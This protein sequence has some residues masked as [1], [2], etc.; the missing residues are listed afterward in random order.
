MALEILRCLRES[1]QI[2]ELFWAWAEFGVAEESAPDFALQSGE[3]LQVIGKDACGGRFCV[4]SRDHSEYL[5][6]ADS[7]GRAGTIAPSLVQGI[8]IMI[9][10]PYWRDCLK[11]SCGGD[12]GEMR[13]AESM[14]EADLHRDPKSKQTRL[15][16]YHAFGLEPLATSLD[17]LHKS[18][19]EGAQTKVV[20][21]S[22]GSVFDGLFNTFSS[23][24][25]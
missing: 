5:L 13:K 14:L 8:Q 6:Y 18:V 17:V 23:L 10:L 20:A 15:R 12:I 11:F 7:E 3:P 1:S 2:Q 24:D 16:L 19:T 4:Y 22:D 9:A 21:T 25:L